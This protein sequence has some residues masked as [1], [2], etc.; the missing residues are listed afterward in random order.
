MCT[1]YG[2]NQTC[3][4]KNIDKIPDSVLSLLV[5]IF[6]QV[7]RGVSRQEKE[8]PR[9]ICPLRSHQPKTTGKQNTATLTVK[10]YM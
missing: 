9:S 7:D 6:G 8:A 10:F 3:K 4:D 5:G 2:D 1:A